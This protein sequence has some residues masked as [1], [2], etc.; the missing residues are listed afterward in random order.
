M[1]E[2]CFTASFQITTEIIKKYNK[3]KK[4]I[5]KKFLFDKFRPLIYAT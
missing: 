1:K 4:Q 2:K 3:Y 5:I